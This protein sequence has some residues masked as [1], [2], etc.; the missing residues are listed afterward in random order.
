[1]II[2]LIIHAPLLMCL[3]RLTLITL[4]IYHKNSLTLFYFNF[5][6][7]ITRPKI[8]QDMF[9]QYFI[10]SLKFFYKNNYYLIRNYNILWINNN[11]TDF[12]IN[13]SYII[14]ILIYHFNLL[15]LSLTPFYFLLMINIKL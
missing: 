15:E 10:F 2:N 9:I 8:N 12:I 13:S 6:Q 1:M 5:I 4:F 14:V 11:I 3:L 7:K